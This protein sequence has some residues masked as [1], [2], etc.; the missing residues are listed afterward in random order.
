MAN[1][2]G[3]VNV[4]AFK[5]ELANSARGLA[6]GAA[7]SKFNASKKEL[8]DSFENS[9]I[10]QEIEGGSS[11]SN[12]SNTLGGYGNLTSFLGFEKSSKP[13]D[14]LRQ[15]LVE[16]IQITI[17]NP[18]IID[19]GNNT[20]SFKYRFELPDKKELTAETPLPAYAGGKSWIDVVEGG[21]KSGFVHY[22]YS[23]RR[24]FPTS[25]SGPAIQVKNE[26]RGGSFKPVPYLTQIFANFKKRLES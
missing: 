17:D 25:R 22:L 24:N 8:L 2:V 23:L 5:L 12:L 10:T 16:D 4:A 7:S 9:P 18:K 15:L 19:N 1:N 3:L 6:F 13:I 14:R 21:D 20:I 26:L 11:E